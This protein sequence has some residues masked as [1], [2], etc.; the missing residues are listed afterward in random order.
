MLK[1]FQFSGWKLNDQ[2]NA[3]V[4][5]EKLQV[6]QSIIR[7]GKNVSG[8]PIGTLFSRQHAQHADNIDIMHTMHKGVRKSNGLEYVI[9]LNG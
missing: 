2:I 3:E 9:K 7:M 4:L 6:K 1:S 8:Y 5:Y